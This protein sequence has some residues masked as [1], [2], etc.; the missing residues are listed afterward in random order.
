MATADAPG[1][2][3]GTTRSHSPPSD[4]ARRVPSDIGMSST[5]R[6]AAKPAA[7]TAKAIS[8]SDANGTTAAIGDRVP[9]TVACR[10]ISDGRYGSDCAAR[11]SS[12]DGC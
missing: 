1:V 7:F 12:R 10:Y 11:R 6:Y 4:P 3:P 9:L 2:S 5:R 8:A